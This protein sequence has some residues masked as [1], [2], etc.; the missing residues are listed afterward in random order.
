MAAFSLVSIYTLAGNMAI[1]NAIMPHAAYDEMV[2]MQSS[3]PSVISAIPLKAFS[4]LGEGN[5]DG[6]IFI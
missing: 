6:I 5:D 1:S 3:I 4:N 2:G